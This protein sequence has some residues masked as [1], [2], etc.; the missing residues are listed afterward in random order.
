LFYSKESKGAKTV[1]GDSFELDSKES[2]V[3]G[4]SLSRFELSERTFDLRF[5]RVQINQLL[6]PPFDSFES[7]E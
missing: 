1:E 5:L 4:T 6:R 3:E 7:F 2:K